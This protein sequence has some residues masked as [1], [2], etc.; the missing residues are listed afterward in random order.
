MVLGAAT[1]TVD[2]CF[3]HECQIPDPPSPPWDGVSDHPLTDHREGTVELLHERCAGLDV[4]KR[5]VKVCVRTPNERRRGTFATT[6]TTWSSTMN[7]IC[8]LREHLL[9]EQVTLVVIE[10]TGDYVRHEGAWFQVGGAV[11][12]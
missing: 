8:D 12:V 11:K 6:T 7:A 5:D 10:A 9:A 1:G 2:C 3:E 4:S